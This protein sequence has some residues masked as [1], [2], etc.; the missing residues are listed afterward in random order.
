ME[1]NIYINGEIGENV[2]LVDIIKQVQGQPMAESFNVYINSVGG[3]V[4]VGFDIYNYL[5]SLNK[6]ITT[7]GNGVVA[8]IAT[9]IF[10]A[11]SQRKLRKNTEFM[12][13]LPSGM[14][15]GTAEEIEN[16]NEVLKKYEKKLIDF[17]VKATG[18]TEEAIRPML[19]NETWLNSSDA[20]D[21]NFTTEDE[22]EFNIAAKAN[23]NLNSNNMTNLSK[24]DKDWIEKG[25]EAIQAL[26]KKPI[27]NIVLQDATGA[28]L[29]FPDIAEGESPALETKVLIGGAPADGSYLMPDGYTYVCEGG[30]LKEILEPMSEDNEEMEALRRE[31]EMLKEQIQAK[32]TE[33]TENAEIIAKFEK[34]FK[35]LKSNIKSKFDFEAKTD[36]KKDEQADEK[37]P[38]QRALE[39]LKS[40]RK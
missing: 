38:A 36:G 12:I 31:N 19:K 3:F 4:D 14:V 17:Y 13:H 26:F 20:F 21:M 35:T 28:E 7:I 15:Q 23:F 1:G 40:K 33:L 18:L 5:V 32:E 2:H 39:N 9:V 34:E 11:G 24:E 37:T 10:M 16:Y 27:K 25:F 6:P 8:S 30:I 29:E 22:I